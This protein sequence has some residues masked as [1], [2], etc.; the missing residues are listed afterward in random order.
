MLTVLLL[1]LMAFQVTGDTLHEWLGIA[2]TVL[3]TVHHILNRKIILFATSG[4]SG[5][6]KTVQNL[7]NSAPGAE[8]V[9]GRVN[10]SEADIAALAAMC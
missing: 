8:I 9:E 6:G 10:P 4:G 2:M 3:L 5:F 1:L 7:K